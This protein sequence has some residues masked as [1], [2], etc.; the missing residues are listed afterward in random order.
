MRIRYLAIL[1]LQQVRK[2]SLQYARRSSL[3]TS[4]V[5][6][7]SMAAPAGFYSDQL[8]S[9]VFDEVVEDPDGVRSATDARDDCGRQF[10]LCLENLSPDLAPDHAMEVANHGGI[11]VRAENASQKIVSSADVGDPVAHGFVDGIFQRARSRFHATH[12]CPQQSHPEDIKLLASH[13]LRA[14]V[15]NALEAEQR[16]DSS[17]GY[18]VLTRAGLGDDAPFAHALGEKCLS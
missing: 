12:F 6:A 5:I 1:I 14:H 18:P 16:A 4:C 2:R 7:E 11:R 13:V 8:H 15:H 17:G 3:K 9:F 10:S